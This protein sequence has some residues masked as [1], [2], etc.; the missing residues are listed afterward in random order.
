MESHH[1]TDKL[2]HYLGGL[3]Y[4]VALGGKR[5]TGPAGA[6]YPF[7]RLVVSSASKRNKNKHDQ[8][9]TPYSN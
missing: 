7:Q 6:L 2:T 9:G 8:S 4:G 1:I 5:D 3:L